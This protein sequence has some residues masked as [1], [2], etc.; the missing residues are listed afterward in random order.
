MKY[1]P[2]NFLSVARKS[3]NYFNV[4]DIE[5]RCGASHHFQYSVH[6]MQVVY[7][8]LQTRHHYS[9]LMP[10]RMITNDTT[11]DVLKCTNN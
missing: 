1:E 3:D 6:H 11:T 5:A 2:S 10:F 9:K 7:E 8:R 4:L